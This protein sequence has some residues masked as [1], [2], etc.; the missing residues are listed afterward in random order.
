[1]R[2]LL[3]LIAVCA[4]YPPPLNLNR[5]GGSDGGSIAPE[6]CTFTGGK[7]GAVPCTFTSATWLQSTNRTIIKLDSAMGAPTTVAAEFSISG[8]PRASTSY[9]GG[10][11]DTECTVDVTEG[12]RHWGASTSMSIGA[13]V[14]T[15][16]T[17]RELS[18]TTDMRT[19][20][21]HGAYTVSTSP[22]DMMGG[23]VTVQLS[24]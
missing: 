20:D 17:V 4:C 8:T 19:Y 13:C 3:V 18:N 21:L 2:W 9:S 7:T 11:G 23:S 16:R 12:M 15:M 6:M 5:D 14:L 1:V 24:F 22:D 10:S